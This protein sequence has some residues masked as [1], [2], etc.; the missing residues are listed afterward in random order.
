MPRDKQDSSLWNVNRVSIFFFYWL[1]EKEK[2]EAE[3]PQLSGATSISTFQIQ[4]ASSWAKLLC[5]QAAVS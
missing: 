5:K 2:G 3:I 1:L 4:D